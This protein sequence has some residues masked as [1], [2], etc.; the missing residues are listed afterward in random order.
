MHD[1]EPRQDKQKS[2]PEAAGVQ[3]LGDGFHLSTF[4]EGSFPESAMSRSA[5]ARLDEII[6]HPER[7]DL[8]HIQRAVS[9]LAQETR[10]IGGAIERSYVSISHAPTHLPEGLSEVHQL[11]VSRS[12]YDRQ[13]IVSAS[14][15]FDGYRSLDAKLSCPQLASL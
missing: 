1:N 14:L 13:I 6:A 5:L 11:R 4:A 7:F 3:T 15:A 9:Y 12:A 2:T 10:D 8:A